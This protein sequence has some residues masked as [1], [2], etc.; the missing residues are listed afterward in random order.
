ML[1]NWDEAIK[2]SQVV[3]DN[4]GVLTT[5]AQLMQGFS[6]LSLPDVVFGCPI[7]DDKSLQSCCSA[8]WTYLIWWSGSGITAYAEALLRCSQKYA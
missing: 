2:Y 3:M 5:A 4:Y 1:Q 7:T 6:T 8:Q